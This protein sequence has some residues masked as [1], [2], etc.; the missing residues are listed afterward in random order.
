MPT[1]DR[2]D[3]GRRAG[4][5]GPKILRFEPLEGRQ[6]LSVG[7]PTAA[8]GARAPDLIAVSFQAEAN[9]DWGRPIGI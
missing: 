8:A 4:S 3:A 2:R 1:Y 6:L 7:V 9:G 5:R